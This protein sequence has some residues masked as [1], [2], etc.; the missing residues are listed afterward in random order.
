MPVQR[1]RSNP[2]RGGT[3]ANAPSLAEQILGLLPPWV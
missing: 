1:R 3:A 2:N